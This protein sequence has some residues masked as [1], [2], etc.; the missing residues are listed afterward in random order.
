MRLHCLHGA[1]G[2]FWSCQF[3]VCIARRVEKT[4]AAFTRT[5]AATYS[6]FSVLSQNGGLRRPKTPTGS[7]C[8][9]A[10]SKTIP[11]GL[12]RTGLG[13]WMGLTR[14]ST[15]RLKSLE[16]VIISASATECCPSSLT[17]P[18]CKFWP[19]PMNQRPLCKRT[20]SSAKVVFSSLEL[21]WP[22]KANCFMP[23]NYLGSLLSITR[24]A[25]PA[26]S[27]VP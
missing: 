17:Q 27:S 4:R 19:L 5:P 1:Q 14:K 23:I 22:L 26:P 16:S 13:L 20:V 12:L 15:R 18:P 24:R 3:G 25:R 2:I 7:I 6:G 11:N 8:L 10:R 9:R 21:S